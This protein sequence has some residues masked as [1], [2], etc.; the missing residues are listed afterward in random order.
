MKIHLHHNN[1]GSG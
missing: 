1:S